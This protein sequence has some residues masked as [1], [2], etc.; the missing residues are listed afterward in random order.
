M[1]FNVLS[2]LLLPTFTFATVIPT[3][4][5][6]VTILSQAQIDVFNPYTHYAAAGG[7]NPSTTKTW[8]CGRHC[9]AVPDFIPTA[10]GGDGDSVQFWFVGFSP[11]LN[12]IIISHQGTDFSKMFPIIADANIIQTSLD[13]TLFP[14]VPSG[15]KVHSGFKESQAD[16]FL[17]PVK[18]TMASH[19]TSNI[20][21][22]GSSSRGLYLHQN[23]PTA[24]VRII[25]YSSPRVG[26]QDFANFV[27]SALAGKVS[28][29]T[30]KDDPV[31]ILPGRFL[32]FH[33]VSGE[34]HIKADNGWASCAGQD[35][36]DGQC[37]TG[38]VPNIFA[39]NTDFHSGP[40]NGIKTV[41]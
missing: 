28:R 10:S 4:R 35:N 25:N 40:F 22:V 32:G 13:S 30:N 24:N 5:A 34:L 37:S 16:R 29:I 11:S 38:D 3:K 8:T 36:T 20:A 2:L 7:C 41:C 31:P 23:L 18:T 9:Q 12:E 19:N 14:G 17:V 33:H 27:D 1:V 26:N 39:G 6:G 15:V 21:V